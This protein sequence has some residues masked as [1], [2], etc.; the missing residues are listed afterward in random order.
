MKKNFLNIIFFLKF[1]ICALNAQQLDATKLIT[2]QKEFPAGSTIYLLFK[3]A[4][5]NDVLFVKN[6]YGIQIVKPNIENNILK[7]RIPYFMSK[8]KGIIN[9]KLIS[10]KEKLTGFLTIYPLKKVKSLETYLGPPSIIAGGKDYTML[11][12]IPTDSLDNPTQDSTIIK[13]KHQFLENEDVNEIKT[14]HNFAFKKIYS[15][16]QTGRMIISSESNQIN[17]T[18]FDINIMSANATDFEIYY[19]RN[20]KY[21]D[22]NQIITFSTSIIRDEYGN[23]ISDGTYVYFTIKNKNGNILTTSGTT[24]NGIATGKIVHPDKE[25]EWEIKAYIHGISESN[26]LNVTFNQAVLELN[27]AFL[28]GNRTIKVGPLKSFLNQMIPDGLKVELVLR[29]NNKKILQTISTSKKGYATFTLDKYLYKNGI[30][31]IEI[32]AA[33]L[34]RKY[35]S[36]KLW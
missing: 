19:S 17:S 34:V 23:T 1:F 26:K 21:A 35:E 30:Y 8:H 28:N 22:G 33:G 20:H 9:W 16:L 31:T 36:I 15:P 12:V 5:K 4:N 25:D 14:K 11:V 18:E 32:R 27:V 7:F 13:V 29:T 24:I 3:N 6:S 2:Q 10:K